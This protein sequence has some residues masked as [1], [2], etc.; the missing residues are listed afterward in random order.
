VLLNLPKP[1]P[2]LLE[3]D[4]S[5]LL[6]TQQY[7]NPYEGKD[8][9]KLNFVFTNDASETV[10]HSI[11]YYYKISPATSVE[12]PQNTKDVFLYPNPADEYTK[13][14]FNSN[15]SQ[16]ISVIFYD[17]KGKE[18]LSKCFT[19]SEIN[20]ELMINCSGLEPGYYIVV[21]HS[22]SE[23]LTQPLIIIR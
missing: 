13:I 19:S 12:E 20:K 7:T 23:V 3:A 4:S 1:L 17:L 10:R 11:V 8:T 22:N 16:N 14:C 6:G 21:I 18:V 15:I 5:L 9:V 2:I